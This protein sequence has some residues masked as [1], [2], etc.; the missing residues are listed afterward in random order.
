MFINNP[1]ANYQQVVTATAGYSKNIVTDGLV[2]YLDAG[3]AA[4]NPGSGTTWYDL[5]PNAYNFTLQNGAA[6]GGS[7]TGSY[8]S[9]DGTND[10]ASNSS[11]TLAQIGAGSEMCLM[12]GV[13]GI[14]NFVQQDLV[15]TA[16]I[17]GDGSY[18]LMFYNGFVRGHLWAN[19]ATNVRD[20]GNPLAT[21][22][23]YGLVQQTKWSTPTL[24]VGRNSV[25]GSQS[26]SGTQPSSAYTGTNLG[27]RDGTGAY[28]Y[29]NMYMVLMYNRYL[30]ASEINQNFTA[31]EVGP[32]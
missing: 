25:T 17:G 22:V 14:N 30:S 7:G 20:D 15:S 4:S 16:G 23:K 24:L 9:F 21:N 2:L 28:A 18:L 32:I 3:I 12:I 8:V 31:M 27:S 6:F 19:G 26:M 10:Y 11:S 1:I 13:L 5:T 29:V